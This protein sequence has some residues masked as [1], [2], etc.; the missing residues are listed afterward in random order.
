MPDVPFQTRLAARPESI[1]ALQAE[2]PH[3]PQD[4]IAYLAESNG[5]EGSVG[6]TGYLRLWPAERI[7]ERNRGYEMEEFAPGIVLI[8]TDGGGEAYGFDFRGRRPRVIAF[9]FDCL[10]A[11]DPYIREMGQDFTE[12]MRRIGEE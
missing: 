4:Y 8:G 11:V 6:A 7:A 5:G 1:A 10:A 9:P 3:L 2:Y 12:F